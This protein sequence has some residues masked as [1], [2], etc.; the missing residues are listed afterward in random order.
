MATDYGDK[1]RDPREGE[2]GMNRFCASLTLGL[3]MVASVGFGAQTGP[4]LSAPALGGPT[5]LSQPYAPDLP[6]PAPLSSPTP[7]STEV[8]YSGPVGQLPVVTIANP[9]LFNQEKIR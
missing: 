7:L 5:L 1:S 2:I 6:M 4:A 8:Q 9:E 3:A